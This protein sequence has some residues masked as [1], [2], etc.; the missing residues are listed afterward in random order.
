MHKNFRT[1]LHEIFMEGWQ[2]AN[3][4]TIKLW[5]RSRSWIRI[6]IH[7]ATLV[8]RDLVEVCTVAVLKIYTPSKMKFWVRH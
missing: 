6:R 4:Q 7:I 5:W 2:W 8:R 3:E 1:D